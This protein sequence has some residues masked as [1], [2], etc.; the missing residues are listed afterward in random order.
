MAKFG[1][2]APAPEMKLGGKKG[3]KKDMKKGGKK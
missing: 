3:G 2:G 1:V